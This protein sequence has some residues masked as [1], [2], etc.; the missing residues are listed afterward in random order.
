MDKVANIFGR[1]Q[2]LDKNIRQNLQALHDTIANKSNLGNFEEMSKMVADNMMEV[3]ETAKGD[4]RECLEPVAPFLFRK[5]LNRECESML[6][7]MVTYL[8]YAPPPTGEEGV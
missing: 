7:D 4:I 2:G 5:K 3:E 6:T 8:E 1:M